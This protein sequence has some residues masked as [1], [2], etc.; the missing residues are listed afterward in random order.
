MNGVHRG[1]RGGWREICRFRFCNT[2][3]GPWDT[4]RAPRAWAMAKRPR[5]AAPAGDARVAL[6]ITILFGEGDGRQRPLR[7]R[8]GPGDGSFGY[9]PPPQAPECAMMRSTPDI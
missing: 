4:S 9:L 8:R 7:R 6:E 5:A 2:I 1:P 3:N